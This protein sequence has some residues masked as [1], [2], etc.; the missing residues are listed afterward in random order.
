VL[1]GDI[2]HVDFFAVD[3]NQTISADVFI[4]YIGESPAV[5]EGNMLITGPSSLSIETLPSKLLSEITIDVSKLTEIGDSIFVRDLDLGEDFIIHNDP[6]E[7]LVRVVQPSAARAEE[8]LAE[9]GE[10]VAEGEAEDEQDDE[11]E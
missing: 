11:D 7:L 10:G 3:A 1:R 2:L 5:E 9:E 4:Q 6:E 8:D